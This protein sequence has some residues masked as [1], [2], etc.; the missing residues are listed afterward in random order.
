MIDKDHP[1]VIGFSNHMSP[2]EQMW[3]TTHRALLPVVGKQVIVH[4][5]ERLRNLGHR[6][7]RVADHLQQPFVRHRLGNGEEWGIALRYSDLSGTSLL[8]ETVSSFG[9]A[10]YIHGDE[11]IDPALASV[12]GVEE[13]LTSAAIEN[14]LPGLHCIDGAARHYRFQALAEKYIAGIK[15]ALDFHRLVISSCQNDASTYTLP[16]AKLH[17]GARADW[18]SSIAPDALIGNSCF[19]GKHC[20]LEPG[21]VLLKNCI[22]GNG[23][24]V[25]KSARL[26]NCVVL[27]NT[28]IGAG[29]TFE[30]AVLSSQGVTHLDGLFIAAQDSSVLCATRDNREASTGLPRTINHSAIRN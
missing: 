12:E 23:V 17:R 18:K 5:L 10:L 6:N 4:N 11:L 7:F 1:V 14:A 9:S 25:D 2:F 13:V 19:I 21:A 29:A 22:L 15:S 30:N 20:R 16:G 26:N 3:P 28:Y 27:P 8:M 24:Y